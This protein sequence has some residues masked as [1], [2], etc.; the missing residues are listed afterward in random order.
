MN[1]SSKP[2]SAELG[3]SAIDLI[4]YH[5]LAAK[6]PLCLLVAFSSFFGFALS[7]HQLGWQAWIVF[8]SVFLL[9]CGGA[10]LNSYQEHRWDRL[11]QRTRRRPVAMGVLSPIH[12][13]RQGQVLAGAGLFL[14]YLGTSDPAPVCAGAVALCLYNVIYTPLKYKTI[15]AIMPGAVCGAIPPYIGWLAGGGPLFSPVIL[16]GVILLIIWQIPH[17]WLVML[18]NKGDYSRSPLPSLGSLLP[19]SNLRLI[20]IVWVAS[21]ITVIHTLIVMFAVM[22]ATIRIMISVVSLVVLIVFSLQMA[23]W[24]KPR[25]RFLFI[26]LNSFMLY[27]M[28][29][30]T[31]GSIVV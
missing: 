9:A 5:L 14:L 4:R 27:T 23:A 12:A 19:E 26:L 11:M 21:L 7:A 29:L 10:S 15:W 3:I 28:A 24:K 22:P 30:F 17:F 1:R 31:V 13:R 25:Y 6:V 20:L 16:G 8:T 2:I 18:S